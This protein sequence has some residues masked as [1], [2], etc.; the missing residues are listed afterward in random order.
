MPT[1]EELPQEW[2]N[3]LHNLLGDMASMQGEVSGGEEIIRRTRKFV[4]DLNTR[5]VP[6]NIIDRL[7]TLLGPVVNSKFL[8]EVPGIDLVMLK[9]SGDGK[10]VVAVC[11]ICDMAI[12]TT[13]H[14][15]TAII[16]WKEHLSKTGAE[17]ASGD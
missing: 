5:W 13:D 1:S 2:Q 10:H 8:V 7:N 12:G 16:R 14:L 4:A 17:V 3:A 11:A 9:P 15:N 6:Q